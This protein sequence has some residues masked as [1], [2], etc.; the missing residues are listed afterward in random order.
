MSVPKNG[1]PLYQTTVGLVA[2]VVVVVVVVVEAAIMSAEM[3][4]C[5]FVSVAR[6]GGERG[7][8]AEGATVFRSR[9]P[10]ESVSMSPNRIAES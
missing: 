7:G 8:G 1:P 2:A 10:R 9:M 6:K 3:P 4:S 5:T